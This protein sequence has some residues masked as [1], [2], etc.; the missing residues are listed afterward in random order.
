MLVYPESLFL[1]TSR[2]EQ[3]VDEQIVKDKKDK[4]ELEKSYS[5]SYISTPRKPKR[6]D[7]HN[8]IMQ[9]VSSFVNQ[10]KVRKKAF[11]KSIVELNPDISELVIKRRIR[12]MFKQR[13][14]EIDKTF[15]T[16]PFVIKGHYWRAI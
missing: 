7:I 14:I 4:I 13:F 5:S 6:K 11:I 1:L 3:S 9:S 10:N 8:T 12:K 15:K 16:K 2:T